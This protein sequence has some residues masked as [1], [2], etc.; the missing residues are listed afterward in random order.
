MSSEDGT[1]VRTGMTHTD[2]CTVT[3]CRTIK[4]KVRKG[5]GY[6][7]GKSKISENENYS[8]GV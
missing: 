1:F 6:F 5:G 8:E 2:E 4:L 3:T 7:Y